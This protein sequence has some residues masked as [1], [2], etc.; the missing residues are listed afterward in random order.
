MQSGTE[1]FAALNDAIFSG[2]RSGAG[3]IKG[4][5]YAEQGDSLAALNDTI[6]S[7]HARRARKRFLVEFMWSKT[8]G[9]A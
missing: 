6:F 9:L 4:G 1:G 2:S 5:I 7:E 8:T 3:K